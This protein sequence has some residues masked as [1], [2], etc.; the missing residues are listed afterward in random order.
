RLMAYADKVVSLSA[1]CKVCGRP[2]TRTVRLIDG[3]P[4]P[5][6]GPRILVGGADRYEARCREHF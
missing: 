4:A 1:V 5:R 6:D 3:K 2:A